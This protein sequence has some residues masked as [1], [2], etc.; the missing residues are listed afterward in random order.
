[1]NRPRSSRLENKQA[2]MA[3][4]SADLRA[5]REKHAGTRR[6]DFQPEPSSPNPLHMSATSTASQ[7]FVFGGIGITPK[8]SGSMRRLHRAQTRRAPS[9]DGR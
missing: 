7:T 4:P 9:G 6:T 5:V 8:G 1:M 2:P 3:I